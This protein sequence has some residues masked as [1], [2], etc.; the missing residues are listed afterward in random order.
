MVPFRP[1]QETQSFM[2]L[3]RDVGIVD[4]PVRLIYL[5]TRLTKKVL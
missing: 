5:V 2:K 3:N 1:A 4:L